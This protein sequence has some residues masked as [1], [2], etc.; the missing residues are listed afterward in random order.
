MITPYF[1]G[2]RAQLAAWG[3]RSR[4]S[5]RQA[6]LAA[7]GQNLRQLIPVHLLAAEDE[8]PNSRERSFP[9]R[10]TCECFIWQMLNPGTACREVV[11]QVQA[12]GRLF[13][14][15]PLDD[16]VSSPYFNSLAVLF[17]NIFKCV[18][19]PFGMAVR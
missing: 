18:F 15:A 14:H 11:R 13:G 16:N 3:P 17:F 19:L 9:L 8:G 1:P 5:L 7:L 10:L 2:L 4:P 6:T 12:L